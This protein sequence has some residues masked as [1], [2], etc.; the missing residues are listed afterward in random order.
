[1]YAYIRR[2][3]YIPSRMYNGLRGVSF[4]GCDVDAKDKYM[5]VKRQ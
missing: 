4:G 5:T 1:M 3:M 2:I